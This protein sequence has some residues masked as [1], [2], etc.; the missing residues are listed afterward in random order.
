M[1]EDIKPGERYPWTFPE[2]EG[3]MGV[4]GP[5]S[6]AEY[7]GWITGGLSVAIAAVNAAVAFELGRTWLESFVFAALTVPFS[8]LL[9]TLPVAYLSFRAQQRDGGLIVSIAGLLLGALILVAWIGSTAALFDHVEN[10]LLSY[11]WRQLFHTKHEEPERIE[12]KQE[13][14]CPYFVPRRNAESEVSRTAA[15]LSDA[16]YWCGWFRHD[17]NAC[18]DLPRAR[19]AAATAKADLTCTYKQLGQQGREKPVVVK[20]TEM[21]QWTLQAFWNLFISAMAMA[22]VQIA[23]PI[24]PCVVSIGRK[25]MMLERY[26]L[27]PAASTSTLIIDTPGNGLVDTEIENAFQDWCIDCME[28][29]ESAKGVPASVFWQS[30]DK[31]W[32]DN[33]Y[34]GIAPK[35]KFEKKFKRKYGHHFRQSDGSKYD[36]IRLKE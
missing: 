23:L 22:I 9:A 35:A 1:A 18:R 16:E 19:A 10:G 30:F 28:E 8:L 12:V 32:G 33:D 13:D 14:E 24:L 31:W 2:R 3:Q 25:G 5:A 6:M 4:F 27:P 26:D 29:D 34:K 17:Q 7:A 11:S 36:G 20:S 21:P 15:R